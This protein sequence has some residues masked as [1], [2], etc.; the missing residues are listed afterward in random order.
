MKTD[1][2]NACAHGLLD[3]AASGRLVISNGRI[4]SFARNLQLMLPVLCAMQLE[5]VVRRLLFLTRSDPS[6]KVL[7]LPAFSAPQ[8][9]AQQ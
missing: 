8:R 1:S 3:C 7:L 6:V 9:C 2:T 4:T 5:A